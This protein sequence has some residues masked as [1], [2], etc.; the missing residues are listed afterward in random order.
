[1]SRFLFAIVFFATIFGVLGLF[2]A[3]V[4]GDRDPWDFVATMF[5][6]GAALGAC[7]DTSVRLSDRDDDR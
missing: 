7:A 5:G 6:V 3:L 1:M 4:H 2:V